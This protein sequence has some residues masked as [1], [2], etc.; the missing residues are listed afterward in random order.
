MTTSTPTRKL[1]VS[2]WEGRIAPVFDC[3]RRLRIAFVRG[4][5]IAGNHE[6]ELEEFNPVRRA[7]YLAGLGIE[8]LLCG[9]VSRPL[10]DLISGHNIQIHAFLSGEAEE[11]LRA[12]IENRLPAPEYIMPGCRGRTGWCSGPG[13]KRGRHRGRGG[14]RGGGGGRGTGGAGWF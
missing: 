10:A 7:A 3:S 14:G 6:M 1:G 13:G 4:K 5:E 11:V 9:A 8:V 12:C 2:I